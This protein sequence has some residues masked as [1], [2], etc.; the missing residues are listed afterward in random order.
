MDR[1]AVRIGPEY[2]QADPVLRI[3][4]DI[5]HRTYGENDWQR[6]NTIV[7]VRIGPT[8]ESVLNTTVNERMFPHDSTP[9]FELTQA[10]YPE[11][12]SDSNYQDFSVSQ[13]APNYYVYI[14]T[15]WWDSDCSIVPC[16][17]RKH[18]SVVAGCQLQSVHKF[19][20]FYVSNHYSGVFEVRASQ[21]LPDGNFHGSRFCQ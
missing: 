12:Q 6:L 15:G 3:F 13:D 5:D 1:N 19:A 14:Q 10:I 2:A 18:M 17:W 16:I 8:Q 4:N 20:A 9:S 21:F 7:R 11:H